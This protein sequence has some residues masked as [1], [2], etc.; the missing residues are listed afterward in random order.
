MGRV[1]SMNGSEKEC[2]QGFSGMIILKWILEEK[3]GVVD[4]HYLAQDRDQQQANKN[5]VMSLWVI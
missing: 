2:I 3:D 5:M 4:L 1:C